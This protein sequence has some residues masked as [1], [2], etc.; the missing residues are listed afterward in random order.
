[1]MRSYPPP[2]LGKTYSK[3][4]SSNKIIEPY[5]SEF[6]HYLNNVIVQDYKKILNNN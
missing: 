4:Q 2:P 3:T 1:M 6:K 5:P